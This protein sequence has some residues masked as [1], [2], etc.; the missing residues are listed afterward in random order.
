M[1]TYASFG[2]G[3]ISSQIHL[4][5]LAGLEVLRD[6]GNA[7]DAAI[8]VSSV[9][10][11]LLP[12]TSSIGGDGFMLALDAGEGMIAYNGSGKSPRNFP[13]EDFLRRKPLRGSL[14]ITVPGLV[15]LW[16]WTWENYCSMDLSRLL[17]PAIS[18]AENGFH[19][20]E[21][22]ARAA[23]RER[24]RLSEYESWRET[25]GGLREGTLI[26]FREL[27]RILKIIAAR[28]CQEFYEGRIA[29]E[30]AEG[31]GRLGAPITYED[32]SSHR[33]MPVS[34]LRTTYRDFEIFELPPNTQGI[35][36]LELLKLVESACTGTEDFRSPDRIEKFFR[37]AALAYTDR[38]RYVADPEYYS[39]DPHVLLGEEEARSKAEKVSIG[40]GDTTFFT[41]GD[42]EGTMVGFIQSIFYPFGSGIVVDGIPFQNR[43]SGFAKERGLPNSPSP[44][45]R[46]M[47]TLSVLAARHDGLGDYIIGCAG[48]DLRPQ[49]H[50]EILINV[51]D[52]G[53]SMS[54]AVDAPRY[55]LLEWR[56]GRMRKAIIEADL[57]LGQ[58]PG[59]FRVTTPKAPG[60]GIVHALRRRKDGVFELVADPR[61]GGLAAPAI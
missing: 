54:E 55:M 53:M 21:P 56:R 14:T 36:T 39:L 41:V 23:A 35:T 7:F 17:K 10:T 18:L 45:K 43:G 6:G 49:I 30:L 25:F 58:V 61:G 26:R 1:P 28:G 42:S 3:G 9:L 60:T 59:W 11:V 15:D 40:G 52:Y 50:A 44:S 22:L 29:E 8:T 57:G 34:P 48:G 5:T 13:V 2:R 16:R 31:L 51:S 20:Q 19:V 47:H 46:P 24:E 27:P 12:H 37:L 38:D 32:F 4:A 33:G